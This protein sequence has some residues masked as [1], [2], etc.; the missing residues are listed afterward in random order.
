[1]PRLTTA[2]K[3]LRAAHK[4]FDREGADAVTMRRLAEMVASRRWRSIATSRTARP[5]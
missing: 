5:C 2:E 1:M 4:L 3:I